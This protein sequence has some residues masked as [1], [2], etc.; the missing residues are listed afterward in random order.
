MGKLPQEL[1]WHDA[2][3]KWASLLNPLLASPIV[4]GQLLTGIALINGTTIV[5]H[6]LGRKIQGYIVVGSSAAATIHDS[7]ATNQMPQLTLQLISN[8]ATTVA[9]WVF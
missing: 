3:N 8:A 7:Q 4:N 9:L 2:D 6:K 1:L 5:N